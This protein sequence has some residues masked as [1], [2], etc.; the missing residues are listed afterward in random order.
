ML[1][2]YY[3]LFPNANFGCDHIFMWRNMYPG[4]RVL[5]SE[6]VLR[7]RTGVKVSGEANQVLWKGRI[8]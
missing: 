8:T 6:K 7:V 5:F 4:D 3:G 2:Y 1:S